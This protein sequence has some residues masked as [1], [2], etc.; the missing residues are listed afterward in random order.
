[1]SIAWGDQWTNLIQPFCSIP[2]LIVTG[3]KL[4]QIYGY[5]IALCLATAMPFAFGLYLA[6][7]A[8]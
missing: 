8:A 7:S 1:M 3:L 4:R 6:Q 2:L 5:L